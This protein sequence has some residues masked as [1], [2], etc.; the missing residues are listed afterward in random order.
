MPVPVPLS[1][2]RPSVA[3]DQKESHE[4]E[5]H[6]LDCLKLGSGLELNYGRTAERGGKLR[7]LF[8]RADCSVQGD[9]ENGVSGIVSQLAL[10][11]Q[12]YLS[13]CLINTVYVYHP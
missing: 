1:C 13:T 5:W 7:G 4:I 11:D 6:S 9:T 8:L 3:N 10:L 12:I 2:P